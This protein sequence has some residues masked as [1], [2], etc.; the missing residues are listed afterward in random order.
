MALDEVMNKDKKEEKPME[1][2]DEKLA[3]NSEWSFA[4]NTGKK[5]MFLLQILIAGFFLVMLAF[6]G[7]HFIKSMKMF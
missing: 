2:V 1:E 5:S 4:I 7:R 6:L 3:S